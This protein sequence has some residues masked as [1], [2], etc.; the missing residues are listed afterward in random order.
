MLPDLSPPAAPEWV[1]WIEPAQ[2]GDRAA[3]ERLL[4]AIAP[5]VHRLGLRLC[6]DATDAEDVLQD[7]L[8]Y[9]SQHLPD[10]EGRASLTTWLFTIARTACLRRRRGLAQRTRFEDPSA[11][12]RVPAAS[13]PESSAETQE[14]LERV[15]RAMQSLPL[16]YQEALALRDVE[17][18]SASEAAS[19]I[20]I[21]VD[22]LKSRLHRAR[23][24]LRRALDSQLVTPPRA[25]PGCPDVVAMWSSKLEGDLSSE[26][27][28]AMEGH[29]RGCTACS[30]AC[31]GLLQILKACQA[32]RLAPVPSAVRESVRR[33]LNELSTA[34][35]PHR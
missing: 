7:T 15:Q 4:T 20:G 11:A 27:C 8:L 5:S 26:D 12:A 16:D 28:S 23:E 34:A 30:D 29:V 17:E 10:F 31:N 9:A 13:T 21:S 6:S 25:N 2:R 24:A 22:A 35:E 18:L 3:L 33:A 32:T 19:V 1:Q 14:L